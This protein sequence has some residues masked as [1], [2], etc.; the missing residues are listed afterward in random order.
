MALAAPARE[1]DATNA[2]KRRLKYAGARQTPDGPDPTPFAPSRA[3]PP[4]AQ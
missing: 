4:P 3:A 1:R 2:V